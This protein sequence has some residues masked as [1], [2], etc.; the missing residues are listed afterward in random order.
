VRGGD[1]LE[2]QIRQL[3]AAKASTNQQPEDGAIAQRMKLVGRRREQPFR[4]A[5]EPF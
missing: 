5:I 1:V 4:L 3:V 2:G